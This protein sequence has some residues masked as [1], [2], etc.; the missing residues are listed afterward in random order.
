MGRRG[1]PALLTASLLLAAVA[2]GLPQD[3][4][5]RAISRDELPKSLLTPPGSVTTV[6]PPERA[7]TQTIY[8]VRSQDAV[9][10]LVPVAVMLPAP[11]NGGDLARTVLERLISNPATPGTEGLSSAIPP[12]VRVRSAVVRDGVLE[13][14]LT[15][16]G[17]VEST[18]QRLAVAQLVYT[19]TAIDG[20]DG[21]RFAI[22]GEPSAVPLDERTAEPGVV[23]TRADFPKIAAT[24]EPTT[25]PGTAP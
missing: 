6:A 18:R 5:P 10:Q 15:D 11:N 24:V 3:T 4:E 21:V 12:G 23:I 22:D 25:V 17:A 13:L 8:L 14:D 16:L 1:A 20:I 2:C 19:A 7:T 9:D